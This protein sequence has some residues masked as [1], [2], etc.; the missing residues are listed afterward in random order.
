MVLSLLQ[1][2]NNF[3]TIHCICPE[4]KYI[5]RLSDIQLRSK[6]K[7]PKTW[8]DSYE[9]RQTKI[10]EKYE[11]FEQEK[12]KIK[13]RNTALGRLDVEKTVKKSLDDKFLKLKFNPY[14]VKVLNH[15]IDFVVFNGDHDE[16]IQDIN[17]VT[18][19]SSNQNLQKL[20]KDIERVISQ[21]A[22]D[23]KVVNI[24]TDGQVR[25]Q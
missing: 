11:K 5:M 9:F 25:V 3:K 22:Y 23:W 2:F 14:D 7:A 19:S 21:K 16:N 10:E 1:I 20:H 13:E 6:A 18:Y 17:L 8:L 4:C 15:P 24:A 12:Q